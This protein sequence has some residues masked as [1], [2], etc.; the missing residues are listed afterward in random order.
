MEIIEGKVQLGTKS[1]HCVNHP[2]GPGKT[3]HTVYC[4]NYTKTQ[5]RHTCTKKTCPNNP[6]KTYGW[7]ALSQTIEVCGS[8]KGTLTLAENYCDDITLPAEMPFRVIRENRNNTFNENYFGMGSLWSSTDYGDAAKMTDE[9]LIAQVRA[10]ATKAQAVNI[11][12]SKD[13]LTLCDYIAIVVTRDGYSVK[14]G[15]NN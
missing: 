5:G 3:Y 4:E 12:R 11:V 10:K 14:A 8:C 1:C 15:W 2:A 9:A 7:H 13:D 6:S